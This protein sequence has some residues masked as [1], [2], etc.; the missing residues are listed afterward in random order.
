LKYSNVY[1]GVF[2]S[3]PNR[4]IAK[5]EVNGSVE[6]AHVKNTGRCREL[7]KQGAT[8]YL[9]RHDSTSRKTGWTLIAV[10]KAERIVNIDSQVPNKLVFEWLKAGKLFKNIVKIVPEYLYRDSRI[11]FYVETESE[12]ILIEVK[13]VTLEE[14]GV[15]LFPDAPTERGVRHILELCKSVE[16]GYRAYIIFVIQMDGIRYFAPNK[17]MHEEFADALSLAK[18]MDVSILALE[19][20]VGKDSI[21]IGNN[22]EVAV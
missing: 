14:D 6:T 16:E 20:S 22:V 19:C 21:S 17:K 3:R 1:E 10:K 9:Q 4:F 13:G 18:K 15:A 11:D 7:L 5:V 2:I 12:K 8:V